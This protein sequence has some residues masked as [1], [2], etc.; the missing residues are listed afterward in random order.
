[1]AYAEEIIGI[2]CD[3]KPDTATLVPERAGN[4]RP[5]ALDAAG[6]RQTVG[7]TVAAY[8]PRH[9]VSFIDPT[10]SGRSNNSGQAIEFCTGRYAEVRTG[11]SAIGN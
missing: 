5:K 6:N 10:Q 2:A 8:R 9:F 4:R 3:V 7:E 11:K 1:M